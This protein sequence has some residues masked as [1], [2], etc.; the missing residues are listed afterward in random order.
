MDKLS[1]IAYGHCEVGGGSVKILEMG[2]GGWCLVLDVESGFTQRN[3]EGT[4]TLS[5]NR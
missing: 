3:I 5:K 1:R 4:G 2:I